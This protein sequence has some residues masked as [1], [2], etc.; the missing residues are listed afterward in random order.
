MYQPV[1]SGGPFALVIPNNHLQHI[2]TLAA[3]GHF[4]SIDDLMIRTGTPCCM[5]VWSGVSHSG[6]TLD[7]YSRILIAGCDMHSQWTR[8]MQIVAHRSILISPKRAHAEL[9]HMHQEVSNRH[10]WLL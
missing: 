6:A 1:Y 7:V 10:Q 3:V 2:G 8:H 9:G 4:Q 5:E